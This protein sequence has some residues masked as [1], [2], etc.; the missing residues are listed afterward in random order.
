[1]ICPCKSCPAKGCGKYHD[2]C[3]E[4]KGWCEKRGLAAA[5]RGAEM[6]VTDAQIEAQLRRQRRRGAK[7]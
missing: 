4:Y 1:M 7:K 2:K 3:A 6:E 5:R